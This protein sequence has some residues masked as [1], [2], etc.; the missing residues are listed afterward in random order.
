ME[1][2]IIFDMDGVIIDSNPYHKISWE[3]FLVKNG[4]P[5]N[6]EIFDNIISGKTGSTSIRLLLGED[7]SEE[8]AAGYLKEIDGDFQ[9]ILRQAKDVEPT[10]GLP[11]FLQ[12]IRSAGYKTALATSAPPGNVD[13]TLERTNLRKYFDVILDKTDVTNGKPDPEVYLNAVN[14]L[15]TEKDRCVVF[16]DSRAGIQSAIS[17]GLRVIGVTT[18]HCRK[19]LLE[20]G[21]SMVIDDFQDLRLEEVMNLI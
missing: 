15:G 19:E 8:I 10:P 11:A 16:E 5:F 17:A 14:R 2:A 6:D 20:E 13:L 3:H 21:V 18:G 4:H 7:L 1:Q 9:E 12:A